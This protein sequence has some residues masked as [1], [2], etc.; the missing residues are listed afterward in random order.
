MKKVCIFVTFLSY[1]YH[2]ARFRKRKVCSITPSPL[3]PYGS[4]SQNPLNGS[5][6]AP[7]IWSEPFEEEEI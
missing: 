5:Q 2:N 3:Y 7:H 4:N 1:V 6:G